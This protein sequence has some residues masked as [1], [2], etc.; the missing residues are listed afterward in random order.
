MEVL[1][2][3][4]FDFMKRTLLVGLMLS[5]MVPMIGVV[6]VNRKTSMVGDAL[7]HTA[8]A[9][10]GVGLIM[11]IDPI[12]GAI[13]VAILSVLSIEK[14]RETFPQHGDMAT[15]IIM[16][17]GLGIAAILSDLAP[18]GN[19][20]DAYLFGSLSSVGV[21]D[22]R[23][24]FVVFIL[25]VLVSLI[26]FSELLDMAIDRNLARISGVNTRW[27]NLS[28]NIL[29][30]ITIAL[31]CK[32]VGALL[33]MSLIVLPVATSLIVAKS[34][35]QTYIFAIVLG[36]IYMLVGI[37]LSYYHDLKPG[38]AIVICA[39]V[40]MA[41]T[42]IYSRIKNKIVKQT[43]TNNYELTKQTY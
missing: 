38:G 34:Y 12:L 7:S 15:A 42:Y 10:V 30:A 14:I 43:I 37:T 27:V 39:I 8:L 11:G 32:V 4:E 23:N 26:N 40:G 16:S 24:V 22:V 6:M 17:L 13:M 31:A 18:G 25:V 41:L 33:V 19:T 5:I 29:S 1:R 28:F 9:G 20:F 21:Q 3:L 36:I 35:K 2:L